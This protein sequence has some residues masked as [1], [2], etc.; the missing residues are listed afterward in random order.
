ME[1]VNE[2][3]NFSELNQSQVR[4]INLA[5]SITGG[6]GALLETILL[7]CLV[8]AK[9]YKTVLQRL[10][11]YTVLMAIVQESSHAANLEQLYESNNTL[12]RKV[13]GALGFVSNW[14]GWCLYVFYL[15][16]ILYLFLLV[17]L[18]VRGGTST[19]VHCVKR[20][21]V[22]RGLLEFTA[23]AITLLVPALVL[24]VPFLN[25]QYGFNGYFCLIRPFRGKSCDPISFT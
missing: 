21:R 5:M 17:C 23:A 22:T 10:F 18:Q 7:L 9:A 19:A 15:V 13:C 6:I 3:C 11:L 14:S 1:V 4:N 2:K 12:Q 25:Q 16:M 20:S 24:W 8:C